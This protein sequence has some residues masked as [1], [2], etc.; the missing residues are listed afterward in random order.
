[1]A[2]DGSIPGPREAIDEVGPQ[3][4]SLDWNEELVEQRRGH[5]THQLRPRLAGLTDEEYLWEPVEGCWSLRPADPA[6]GE[7]V[8][9]Q[10]F[11]LNLVRPSPDPAPVT[12]IAWR[13]AHLIVSVLGRRVAGILGG[14]PVDEASFPFAGTA[15]VALDQLDEVYAAWIDGVRGLGEAGLRRPCGP[16]ET[17]YGNL[18]DLPRASLV[19]H[20]SRE[21]IHHGAEIALLRDLHR[22]G[23]R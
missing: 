17:A 16:S 10:S 9:G 1:M 8:T 13:L 15:A 4:A 2:V 18:A 12:T 20:I 23:R 19:L 5:W 6:G 14:P 3:E 7:Q 21:L 11:R 22:A